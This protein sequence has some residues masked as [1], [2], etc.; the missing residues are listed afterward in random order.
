MKRSLLTLATCAALL[1]GTAAAQ[2]GADVGQWTLGAGGLW[3]GADSDR[4]LKNA[5]GF[6]ANFGRAMSEHWD[7]GLSFFQSNHDNQRAP[8]DREIKGA[9]FDVNQSQTGPCGPKESKVTT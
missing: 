9:T 3:T 8:G 2:A 5:F 4:D 1:G 7:T 6:Y